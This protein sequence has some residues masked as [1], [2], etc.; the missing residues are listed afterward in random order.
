[1]AGLKVHGQQPVG[2]SGD[3]DDFVGGSADG[4]DVGVDDTGRRGRPA[5]LDHPVLRRQLRQMLERIVNGS[6]HYTGAVGEPPDGF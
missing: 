4:G 6:R 5:A 2:V 3:A 1:M